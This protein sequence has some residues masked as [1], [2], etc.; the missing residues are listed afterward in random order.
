MKFSKKLVVAFSIALLPQFAVAAGS[1][2]DKNIAYVRAD[3]GSGEYWVY[4]VGGSWNNPD[5]CQ[6]KDA[7]VIGKWMKGYNVMVATVLTAHASGKKISA[8]FSGCDGYQYP[9]ASSIYMLR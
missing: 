3:A 2:G 9:R 4:P 5:L 7:F 1:S 6:K 8:W